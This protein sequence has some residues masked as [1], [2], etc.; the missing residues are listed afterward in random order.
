VQI[1]K[2]KSG[3]KLVQHFFK[4]QIEIPDIWTIQKIK[5]FAEVKSG[6]TPSTNKEKY[7]KN[8]KIPW[9][10]S[11]KTQNKLIFK[12]STF[13]TRE[14]LENSAAK[15]FPKNTVLIAL[16]GS[17]TG[18][19]GIL[20]FDCST[21]QSITGIYPSKNHNP[22]FLFYFLIF[23][24]NQILRYSIGSAQPHINQGIVENIPVL[25]PV[26]HEQ[27]KIAAIL[28]NV[29]SLIQQSEKVIELT[30]RLK[31]GMINDLFTKGIGHKKFK[32]KIFGLRYIQ[33][34]IPEEWIL[35]PIGKVCKSIV[36]GRNKP[37]KFDGSIPWLTVDDLNEMFVEKSKKDLLVS[38]EELKKQSGKI[39]P[40][41]SVLISCVGDLGLIAINKIEISMNQQLHAF[42]CPANLEP[43]YLAFFLSTM[44][45]YMNGIATRTT[46]SYMNKDN[47]ESIPIAIPPLEEQRK[48][49]QILSNIDFKIKE[50]MNYKSKLESIKK[51][52]MQKL[53]TGK[54]RVKTN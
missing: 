30:Q 4:K 19:V 9:I 28:S 44:E 17:T 53:L 31:K 10:N 3:N 29:D 14:G 49:I 7:W 46:V 1:Q 35:K 20:T 50:N 8:G 21:N 6:G 25:L 5:K 26:L 15:L 32:T 12:E 36:S 13:I 18:K 38:K 41:N 24:R 51:G 54:I 42:R 2:A 48:I 16:T 34:S 33:K 22:L 11:S 37:K 39:V 23:Y 47:C 45:V 52:L 43:H 27:N 40:S